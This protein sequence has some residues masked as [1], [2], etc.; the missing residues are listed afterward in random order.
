MMEP[1][2][3]DQRS[4]SRCIELA[5]RYLVRACFILQCSVKNRFLAASRDNTDLAK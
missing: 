4:R 1:L 2:Q 5:T 3:S